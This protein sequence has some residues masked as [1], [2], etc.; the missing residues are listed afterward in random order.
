MD[1]MRKTA[2]STPEASY[3][4]SYFATLA[5]VERRHFWFRGRN[6]VI[7]GLVRQITRQ[8]PDG[9]R[10]L[11]VGCGT[12]NVLHGLREA[13]QR[14]RVYGLDLHW[15]GLEFARRED[16]AALVQGD[17]HHAPF[18]VGFDLV[19][20]FDVLEH[21]EDERAVLTDLRGLLQPGGAL[22]VTVPADPALWSYFDEAAHHVRRYQPQQLRERLEENGFRV[23]YLSPY[24]LATYPAVRLG[25]WLAARASGYQAGESG[26]TERQL[27]EREL[28]ITPGINAFLTWVLRAEAAWVAQRRRLPRGTS[29]IALARA[30]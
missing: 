19:G 6:A 18:G 10:V 26:E 9:F 20:L 17:A 3:D 21:L 25:R 22:L 14:G 4:P 29:L 12:G 11:E 5:R 2:P 30:I 7:A 28:R 8:L 27:V 13:C 24:M 1:T 15:Q 23:E 16:D